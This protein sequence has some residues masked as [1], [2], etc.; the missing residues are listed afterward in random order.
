MRVVAAGLVSLA[1]VAPA[2][3][4]TTPLAAGPARAE[5]YF[6]FM[7]ARRLEAQG[8]L[9]DALA[10]LERARRLDPDSAEL[11]AELAGFHARQDA[12]V[13]AAA[14][15]TAALARDPDNLEAN[16]ILGL[17]YAAW[18]EGVGDAP[19][20]RTPE[21]LRAEAIDHLARIL[22]TP[23]V[24]TDPNLQLTLARLYMAADRHAEA[25][26]V[27]QNIISQAPFA[28]EPFTMLADARLR[29]GETDAA[30]DALREAGRIDPRYLVSLGDLLERER[31]Y[32]E[33]AAVYGEVVGRVEGASR[34]LRL[35]WYR[36][37]LNV[38]GGAGAPQAR[39]GLAEFVAA[40]PGDAHALYLLST[41]ERQLGNTEAAATA[42]RA[43]IALDPTSASGL[44]AL[45]VLLLENRDY[46]GV[47]ELLA[48]FAARAGA[49]GPEAALLSAQL[50]L[51]HLR[52]GVHASAI[53]ALTRARALDP[54][55]D[56]YATLLA[57]AL[58][59]A[60]RSADAVTLL[61][62]AVGAKPG[63]LE[64]VVALADLHTQAG[65]FDDAMR[66]L[67]EAPPRLDA[68]PGLLLQLGSVYEA[69]GRY[70][71]AERELRRVLDR[72]PHHAPALNFLGYMLADRGDRLDE[73]LTLIERALD[74]DPDNPSYQDSLGW[75]LFKQ[76]RAAEAEPHLRAAAERL[77]DN[78]VVQ[79]H[80]GDV[81]A[82]L[83]RAEAA[84]RAWQRALAGDG[85][86]VDRTTIER[87]IRDQRR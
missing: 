44:Y 12:P 34:D 59:G 4:Q 19:D 54:D 49:G 63:S 38:P 16:R 35:R 40:N 65:H 56:R 45:S 50:G 10:S 41:A 57:Q 53:D 68:D 33:A 77:A 58:L 14:A 31:R 23:A 5:A 29:L 69:A 32:A 81:L 62:G 72:D 61:E 85:A 2:S 13:Q 83:G 71:D 76:G 25:A 51:A 75:A 26:P 30:I 20:G 18:A 36:A 60:Q 11:D 39:G 21:V 74:V 52:L 78:S 80:Y 15:A 46:Q 79:D 3:A 84:I 7:Q 28:A 27:L 47:V 67:T 6:E 73:A 24:A 70:D 17:V 87:K 8:E 55:T 43:L 86:D 48:P 64:L 1:L 37:L 82:Q 9:A 42:A 22:T 66:V